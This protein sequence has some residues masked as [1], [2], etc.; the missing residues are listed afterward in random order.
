MDLSEIRKDIDQIDAELLELFIRRM[1]CAKAVAAYKSANHLPILSK[2]R[3]REILRRVTEESGEYELYAH[4]L[5]STLLELS[6]TYQRK[7]ITTGSNVR[8]FIAKSLENVPE[9]FPA[10]GLI[11]CQGVEGAYSQMAADKMFPRGNIIYFKT[12]EAVFDAVESG[13]CTFGVLPIENSSN[14]SVRAVYDLLQ[15]KNV[16]IVRS[17][18]LCVQHELFVKP[19]VKLS[20]VKK[21]I[22]HEQALGQCSAFLKSLGDQVE[23]ARCENTALAAKM[24]AESEDRGIAAI[25][26]SNCAELYGLEALDCGNIQ[27][28]D[29]NYTR[30]ICIS[31][32]PVV[33]PGANRITL[34]L[35]CEHR[36]GALYD[37][38]SHIS[39]LELNL[40]K[41]ES[42]PMVGHDFEFL[43]FF[44]I[45]ASVLDPKVVDMLESLEH[46]CRSM[47]YLGN[48]QEV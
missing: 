18:R 1:D 27:N 24:V 15:V 8:D 45:E 43:F 22:S 9:L 42:C 34:V 35:S 37:V 48:Y 44:E 5:F 23:T 29:N 26:S 28:S 17:E 46:S 25:S 7:Y 14:G 40:I 12:F 47:R 32:T 36:P 38:M 33:Y 11:A 10:T 41:L 39:A 6:R 16:S 31:K 2:E 4:R 30:F 21:I 20:E 13:L 19:G 3:E